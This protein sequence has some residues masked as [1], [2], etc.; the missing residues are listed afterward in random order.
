MPFIQEPLPVVAD[1]PMREWNILAL[2]F[3]GTVNEVSRLDMPN[4][5]EMYCDGNPLPSLPWDELPSLVYLYAYSC[6]FTEMN[7]WQ[8]P[9]LQ[10]VYSG[11]NNNLIS[12]DAHDNTSLSYIGCD[13]CTALSFIDLSGCTALRNV[14]MQTC[15]FSV[16]V[17]DQVLTDL[18]NNG[19]INGTVRLNGGGSAS[20]SNPDGLALKAILID[21]GWNVYHN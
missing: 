18:V 11:G 20:P 12:L 7:L 6:N 21:R 2:P 19:A 13:N 3:D 9:S 17:V 14:Y 1:P 15:N 4:M 16:A 5:M 10:Y 8:S